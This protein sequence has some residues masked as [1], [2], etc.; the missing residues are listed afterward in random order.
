M[1]DI[2]LRQLS[3]D[4]CCPPEDVLD[5]Q[6]HFTHHQFLDGRRR[7]Q[8]G[9]ECFLKIAVVNGKLLFTGQP[10]IIAWC[11]NAYGSSGAE[12]FFEAKNMRRLN[13]RLLQD[14]HQIEMMHPFYIADQITDVDTENAV[15][16]WYER[17]E[18][19]QFRGDDRYDKAFSFDEAAPDELGVAAICDGQIAGMAGASSDSP[20]MWQIG[21]NV[22]LERRR[23]G[24][25]TM[26]VTLLKNEI[27]KRGYLPYYGTA[28]SHLA[29]QR[30]AL[31]SGFL[32][33]WAELVTSSLQ[34]S[35]DT[36]KASNSPG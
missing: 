7:F 24:I 33:A 34:E 20:T 17:E 35:I 10:E 26:L 32:P 36:G 30:V 13:D 6:N 31:A 21:I 2:L 5:G 25:G 28:F 11:K 22:S 14:A 27:L 1:N 29:S 23:A 9:K 19:E 15:I 18:I 4:Y 8:E 16:R 3:V 12:W